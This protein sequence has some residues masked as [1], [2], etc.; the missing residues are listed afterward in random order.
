[1]ARAVRDLKGVGAPGVGRAWRRDRFRA[2]DLRDSLWS[3]GYAVDTLETATD[4]TTLPGLAATLGRTLR[5]GLDEVGER[6]HAFSHLSHVYPTGSSLYTTYVFRLGAD[7]D[8]TLD[9]WRRLKR[10]AS[11]VITAH[12]ATITHQHGVGTDHAPYLAA[13][14]GPLGMAALDAVIRRLDP[15]GLMSPGV[16]MPDEHS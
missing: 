15:D 14:K 12:G 16:L 10:E 9:R 13:E 4:W 2:P 7:P 1:V 8:E 5:H 6:V 3:A 11:E